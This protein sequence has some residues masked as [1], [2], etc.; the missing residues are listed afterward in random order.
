MPWLCINNIKMLMLPSLSIHSQNAIR[1]FFLIWQANSK[2]C[3]E[4]F[5]LTYEVEDLKATWSQNLQSYTI[6]TVIIGM[7]I[8]MKGFPGGARG[9]EPC[10]CRKLKERQ[11]PTLGQEDPLEEGMATHSSILAWR[12]PWREEP[13]GLQS[14]KSQRAGH[15]WIN[16]AGTWINETE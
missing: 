12:I 5:W 4:M 9:K 14:M 1:A 3:M 7:K 2:R 15:D 10:Q 8:D 6:K 11:A 13:G 16:L